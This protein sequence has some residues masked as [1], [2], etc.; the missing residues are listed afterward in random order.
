MIVSRKDLAN[1]IRILSIDAVQKANSGHPGAPMGM[2][3]IAEVLWRDYLNHSPNNPNWFDRDRFVLSNGHSSMLIYSLLHLSGY[4]L[5]ITDLK[6]FRKMH[7]KTPG[8]PEYQHTVGIEATTGPLGQGLANAIGFAIA[9]RTLAKQFNKKNLDIVNHYTY[10]FVGDGCLMEGISHE[11]SSLAGVLKLGKLIVFYDSNGISIDGK[12]DKWFNDDTEKRFISYGWHVINHIDGHNIEKIQKAINESKKIHDKPSLLICK[13]IIGFGS[14]NKSGTHELHGSPLG[15]EEI[16]LVRKYLKWK[17]SSFYIPKE[18]YKMWNAQKSGQKKE[19]LWNKKILQYREKYPKL[20]QEFNRRICNQLPI[21]WEKKTKHFFH[22]LN[23]NPK[24]ISTRQSSQNTIEFFGQFI[25][26]YLGGSADLT[27]SNLT[28]W[29]GS[30]EINQYSSGNYIHYGVREFGMIAIANGISLHKGFLPYTSTFLIFSDYAR[31]AIR[32]AALMKIRHIMIY[33]HDSIGLGEDGPTHQ[34]VE[35]ISSLRIIPNMILWR[36]CD[37]VECAI[38]WKY[39]IEN[40]NGP[41]S[42]ILSRQNL[43]QQ[44]RSEEQLKNINKGAY[45]LKDCTNNKI[46]IIF[47]A[48]GSEVNLAMSAYKQLTSEGYNVRVISAPSTNVFDKQ[49]QSYKEFLLPKN[50]SARVAIEAGT[51]NFWYKY[52]GLKGIVV[53]IDSFGASAPAEEL[54]NFFGFNVDNIVKQ[55]KILIQN[56]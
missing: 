40:N 53:G 55:A 49:E 20:A 51:T 48:T 26:E 9:E 56:N 11:V 18:I 34:P 23:T 19:D 30:K 7:S 2:A 13:T 25:P 52:I 35:Q 4:D 44:F 39:A 32:M 38:A 6:N 22:T 3:D 31:S 33:T 5:S 14:P 15:E 1:A 17:Y 42:L 45:I 36:P 41:T 43:I 12:V 24:N 27:P 8:H 47:I 54:F 46:D 37:Q 21:D 10:A 16:K 29:S 50:I 28:K